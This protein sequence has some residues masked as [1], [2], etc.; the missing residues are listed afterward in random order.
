MSY[1]LKPIRKD[2]TMKKNPKKHFKSTIALLLCILC[3]FQITFVTN[4]Q[5]TSTTDFQELLNTYNIC[6]TGTAMEMSSTEVTG[7]LADANS[8]SEYLSSTLSSDSSYTLMEPE[9]ILELHYLSLT[10]E[11]QETFLAETANQTIDVSKTD[12]VILISYNV[13]VVNPLATTTI[14]SSRRGVIKMQD[15]VTG[16]WGSAAVTL[17]ANFTK[18]TSG[19]KWT[20]TIK[21]ATDCTI[22]EEESSPVQIASTTLHWGDGEIY[23]SSADYVG[24][25]IRAYTYSQVVCGSNVSE[26]RVYVYPD[27]SYN[28]AKIN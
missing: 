26:L 12:G 6:V 20:I 3:A 2:K 22:K 17:Y 21:K 13:N 8:P 23:S 9:T 7:L 19:S 1:N 10:P 25:E 28:Y 4:A 16:S 24:N 5:E 18:T 15:S 11:E 14:S 27:S